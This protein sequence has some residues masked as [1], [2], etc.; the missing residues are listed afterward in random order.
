MISPLLS[1][2]R[3][4]LCTP[5]GKPHLDV[6]IRILGFLKKRLGQGLFFKKN[7][8]LCIEGYFDADWARSHIDKRSITRFYT[9]LYGNMVIWKRKIQNILARSIA[10]A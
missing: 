3:A 2:S 4:N 9:F 5:I 8:H 7:D 10:E 6:V 1:V